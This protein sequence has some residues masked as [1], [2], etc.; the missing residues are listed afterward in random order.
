MPAVMSQ[1]Q[2]SLD[3]LKGLDTDSSLKNYFIKI[4]LKIVILE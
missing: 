4:Q 3:L 2:P 1:W